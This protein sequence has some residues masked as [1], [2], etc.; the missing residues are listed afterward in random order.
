MPDRLTRRGVIAAL[1]AVGLASVP[2][3]AADVDRRLIDAVRAQDAAEVRAL[4]TR[5]VDVNVSAD[6]G[7][8]FSGPPTRTI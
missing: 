8:T 5:R 3:I 1:V 7:S 6:D 2:L 4:L